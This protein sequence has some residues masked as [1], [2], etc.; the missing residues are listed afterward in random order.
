[1]SREEHKVLNRRLIEEAWNQGKIEV[2][3]AILAHD[4]VHHEPTAPERRN[5]DD[6][7]Q[8]LVG[9]RMAFPDV[10]IRVDDELVDGEQIVTR[11]TVTGTHQGNLEEPTGTIPPT[12][13]QIRVSGIT[14]ARYANG[15][16]A[17]E[18]QVADMLSFTM[19]LGLMSAPAQ[20]G[21]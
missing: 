18:W 5:R 11:W 21:P 8:H 4:Y 14:I 17:E 12:G 2:V 1:M 16:L 7:K 15:K 19:Q 10:Q 6:Y 9:T 20:A 3:D 13:R